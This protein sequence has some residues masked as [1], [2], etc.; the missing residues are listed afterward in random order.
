[1]RTTPEAVEW[2]TA[3]GVTCGVKRTKRRGEPGVFV[4]PTR[5][6]KRRAA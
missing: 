5:S 4:M 6:H 1:M 2:R 3:E